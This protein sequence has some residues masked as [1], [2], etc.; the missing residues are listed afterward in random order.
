MSPLTT[1]RRIASPPFR[2][3]G[4]YAGGRARGHPRVLSCGGAGL[5]AAPWSIPTVGSGLDGAAWS[6]SKVKAAWRRS[7]EGPTVTFIVLP[8]NFTYPALWQAHS[9]SFAVRAY[10]LDIATLDTVG[11]IHARLPTQKITRR[12][13]QSV[14]I[15]PFWVAKGMLRGYRVRGADPVDGVVDAM[16]KRLN[17]IPGDMKICHRTVD[18][19]FGTLRSCV[20]PELF[21]AN[22]VDDVKTE[23]GLC[24][25]KRITSILGVEPLIIAIR[26]Y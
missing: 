16:L 17:D 9:P 5:L 10:G 2:S 4:A 24:D 25:L 14:G 11:V 7:A 18:R 23:M 19:P 13:C 12:A 3:C 22:G 26:A 8:R 1:L 15:G 20:G 6:I 21:P